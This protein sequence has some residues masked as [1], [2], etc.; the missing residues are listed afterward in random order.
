MSMNLK[1]DILNAVRNPT[2]PTSGSNAVKPPN[3]G[4][5]VITPKRP[6]LYE[7]PCGWCTKWDK[8]CDLKT[9]KS[10]PPCA[11]CDYNGWNMPQCRECNEKNDYKY[12][13]RTIK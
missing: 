5:S 8:K 12:F 1:D 2:P 6:C 4:S 10:E 7:T 11:E 13:E 3:V 9:P